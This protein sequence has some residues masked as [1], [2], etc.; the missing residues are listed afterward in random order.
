MKKFIA[1]LSFFLLPALAVYIIFSWLLLPQ[2]LIYFYGP[3]IEQ[4]V[5][6]SFKSAA[7]R[8]YDMVI[9]GNSRLYCG[10]N[11]DQFAI[12]TF[13]F[14]HNN[15]SYNQ[16]YYKLKWILNQKKKVKHVILG[17]DY[18]QF[19]IF[20]DTRNYVYGQWFAPE[21]LQDYRQK[22]YWL[23]HHVDLLR[24]EKIQNLVLR[25]IY[26][27]DLKPNGQF[28]R[29]GQASADDFIKREPKRLAIQVKYFEQILQLCKEY[30][31]TVFICMPPLRSSEYK[32]YTEIQKK[33]Y[34]DFLSPYLN[35]R[36]RYLDFST[37]PAFT[38]DD[39]VDISHLNQKGADRFS[40]MLSDQILS[41]LDQISSCP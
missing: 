8:N 5:N 38:L 12:P 30:D 35:C 33:E 9:L 27:H 7:T 28:V 2:L 26:K 10:A 4:Q 20:S 37:N 17:I 14:S 24:P 32:Q 3:N 11:P 34:R 21:Y 15:D 31:I 18:F 19:G 36:I 6:S 16:L 29:V 40:K 39:F 22:N 41:E 13:N 25:P 23:A 1:K